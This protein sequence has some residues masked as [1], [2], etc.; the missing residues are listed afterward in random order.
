VTGREV[1][2]A[3]EDGVEVG[4]RERGRQQER[5]EDEPRLGAHRREVAEV[6]G[7]RAVSDGLRRNEPAVEVHA[8]DAGVGGQYVVCVALALHDRGVVAWPDEQPVGG[9]RQTSPDAGDERALSRRRDGVVVR[10][11]RG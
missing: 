3:G 4:N 11:R 9:R 2:Q 5:D 1:Q 7:E 8:L 6:H 10:G